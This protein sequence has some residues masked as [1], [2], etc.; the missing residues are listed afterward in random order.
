M[1]DTCTTARS[2]RRKI[3]EMAGEQVEQVARSEGTWDSMTDAEK[4]KSKLCYIGDCMQHI[5]NILI[6][7][8]AASAESMLKQELQQS[9]DAFSAFERMSTS[10]MQLIRAVRAVDTYPCERLM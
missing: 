5:R 9:L 2:A 7:A 6:D 8:M 3:I 10:P 4:D 1:S